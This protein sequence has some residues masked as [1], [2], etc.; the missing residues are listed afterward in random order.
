M[1]LEKHLCKKGPQSKPH[2]HLDF[3]PFI[4]AL[5]MLLSWWQVFPRFMFIF[6]YVLV[7]DSVPMNHERTGLLIVGIHFRSFSWK[8]FEPACYFIPGGLKSE[9]T[10]IAPC[11]R[12]FSRYC[13]QWPWSN[14]DRLMFRGKQLWNIKVKNWHW[15]TGSLSIESSGT[16]VFETVA[17]VCGH[18]LHT[19]SSTC[20]YHCRSTPWFANHLD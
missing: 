7:S 9:L 5:F 15:A 8:T 4:S 11:C 19:H 16:Y 13:A 6:V 20:R 3:L 18:A 17:A 10:S 14:S 2:F 1:D 12:V